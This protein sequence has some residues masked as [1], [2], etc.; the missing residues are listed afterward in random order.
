MAAGVDC[1]LCEVGSV[2]TANPTCVTVQDSAMEALGMMAER[3]FRHLPVL[4]EHGVVVG[5]LDIAK[6]LFDAIMRMERM[7]AKSDKSSQQLKDAVARAGF[8]WAG[9]HGAEAAA[10]EQLWQDLMAGSRTMHLRKAVD[11]A[12]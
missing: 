8:A 1:E 2:M 6:C 3:G 7:Q 11:A 12:D 5:V 4:D 10:L 9:A